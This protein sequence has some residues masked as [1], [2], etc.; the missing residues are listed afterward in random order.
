MRVRAGQNR[1]MGF[2]L[3]FGDSEVRDVVADVD[4][5]RVRFAAASVRDADGERGWL[6]SVVLTLASGAFTGD[7]T[8]AIGRIA[9]ARVRNA[10]RDVLRLALPSTLAGD[11]ELS[12]RFANGTQLAARG[13][14]LAL[15]A[16][17]DARFTP[18]LSC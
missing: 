4:V 7:L 5:L 14:A 1:R 8:H 18:D 3:E 16:A 10:G 2:V 13:Q 9:E 12:L 11:L 17:D 15:T 6:A